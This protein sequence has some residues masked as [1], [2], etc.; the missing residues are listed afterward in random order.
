MH[1]TWGGTWNVVNHLPTF[2]SCTPAQIWSCFISKVA[3]VTVSC[4]SMPLIQISGASQL[5]QIRHLE[6]HPIILSC[7]YTKLEVW[8]PVNDIY[9]HSVLKKVIFTYMTV[10]L[11]ST[12][13]YPIMPVKSKHLAWRQGASTTK[14][15]ARSM[16][17]PQLWSRSMF[18]QHLN[19][20]HHH[21]D[22]E[23]PYRNNPDELRKTRMIKTEQ[24]RNISDQRRVKYQRSR[25]KWRLKRGTSHWLFR[26]KL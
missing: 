18:N 13:W 15:A 6:W 25:I 21:C 10:M 9:W 4:R 14:M 5:G 16:A 17:C 22:Q 3:Q 26:V 19:H 24:H 11:G 23:K 20:P 1:S 2:A 12:V 8:V 7:R